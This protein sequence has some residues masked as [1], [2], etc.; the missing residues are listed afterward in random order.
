M[1]KHRALA[2][3]C[4]V[5]PVL[6][7]CTST[8][9]IHSAQPDVTMH[10]RGYEPAATPNSNSY[11]ATSFGNYDFKATKEGHEPLYG[12]LP[13]QFHPERVVLDALFFAPGLFFNLRD[14]YT[15][16]EVDLEE[17]VVR[18]KDK[19][20]EPWLSYK[21]TPQEIERARQYFETQDK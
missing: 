2:L 8:S 10:I 21:P 12:I 16:Y 18:Y 9:S 13:M 4:L 17:G 7:G 1:I 11:S 3:S 14:T 15:F 5:L 19:E 20:Q 6:A